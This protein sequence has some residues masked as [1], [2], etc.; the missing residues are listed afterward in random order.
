MIPEFTKEGFLPKGIYRASIDEVKIRF[1]SSNPK[2]G[3]LFKGLIKALQNLKKAGIRKVYIDGS[4]V[5]SKTNP[6]DID[7]CWEI[8]ANLD[9]QILDP[10][11]QDFSY[12]RRAMKQKYNVEFFPATW[13]EGDSGYPFVFFFQLNRDGKEKGIILIEL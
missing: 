1:G 12:E 2:R 13:I 10:V 4:F 5:S 3:K 8:T 6:N 9:K 7:G 11:F